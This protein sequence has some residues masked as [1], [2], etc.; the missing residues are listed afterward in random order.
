MIAMYGIEVMHETESEAVMARLERLHGR[1]KRT[2]K[3]L[4]PDIR[5]LVEAKGRQR[6]GYRP[7]QFESQLGNQQLLGLQQAVSQSSPRL[8]GSIFGGLFGPL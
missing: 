1:I 5:Y 3:G 4:D 6:W 2:I 8:F 7:S